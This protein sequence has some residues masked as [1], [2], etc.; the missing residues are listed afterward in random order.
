MKRLTRILVVTLSLVSCIGR[1]PEDEHFEIPF[2]NNSK[3]NVLIDYYW[4]Y[5]PGDNYREEVATEVGYGIHRLISFGQERSNV[6]SV[7]PD[8]TN[9]NF[10]RGQIWWF[11]TDTFEDIFG[12]GGE[13]IVYVIKQDDIQDAKHKPINYIIYHFKSVEYLMMDDWKIKYPP[14]ATN[15]EILNGEYRYDTG[16][17]IITN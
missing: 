14:I 12:W 15:A 10:L 17:S 16:E 5:R 4:L 11:Q 7:S 1:I 9:C 8:E 13:L 2:T 6:I 3:D